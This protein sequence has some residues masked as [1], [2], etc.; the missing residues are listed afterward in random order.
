VA[1][2]E[3][4]FVGEEPSDQR[5]DL[6][7]ALLLDPVAA[8]GKHL[9]PP[10]V[11]QRALH[12]VKVAEEDGAVSA[13]ADEQGGLVDRRPVGDPELVPVAVEVPVAVK[14]TGEPGPPVLTGVVA[15][16]SLGE[17]GQRESRLGD[18]VEQARVRGL[19]V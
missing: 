2:A 4:R 10:E 12:R 14:G 19:P 9:H 11:G 7:S 17:P 3:R 6:A 1:A 15:D 13:P 8:A 5:V 16:I 18:V